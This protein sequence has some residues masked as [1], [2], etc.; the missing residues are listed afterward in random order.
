MVKCLHVCCT[1]TQAGIDI[2][3]VCVAMGLCVN[4][5]SIIAL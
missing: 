3:Y 4:E 5:N 1:D 2:M